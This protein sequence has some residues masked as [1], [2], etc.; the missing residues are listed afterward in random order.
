MNNIIEGLESISLS[1]ND[2]RK[3]LDDKVNIILYPDLHKYHSIDQLLDPYGCCIILYV[4]K[5]RPS[6]YGHW[7]ALIKTDD[8]SIEFFNPYGGLPDESLKK[9]N[10]NFRADTNQLVPYLKELMYDSNYDLHYNEFQF[11]RKGYD[12]NTCGRHCV[13]R[14]FYKILNIYEYKKLLDR[15]C[16]MTNTDYDGLVTL[17]TSSIK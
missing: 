12:I 3:L 13:V 7:C 15:A 10:A 11:Q 14:V 4:H 9:L 2:I 6:Y 8:K 5:V 16:K 1:D 17:L